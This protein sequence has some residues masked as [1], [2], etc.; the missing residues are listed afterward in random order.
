MN[1]F[2]VISTVSSRCTIH[3]KQQ[4]APQPPQRYDFWYLARAPGPNQ[5]ISPHPS[6]H[7]HL[8]QHTS[9]LLRLTP[10]IIR[11]Q[12]RTIVSHKRLLELVFLI[13]VDVFLVVGDDGFGYGLADGVDLRGVTT[14]RDAD[15]D[16]DV[17]ELIEANYEERFVDLCSET[18][19]RKGWALLL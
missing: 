4:Q 18:G 14:T 9:E 6:N 8:R 1:V 2:I 13:L 11:N 15:A 19:V 17:G 5:H 12:Q 7:P 10:P 16:V 3:H